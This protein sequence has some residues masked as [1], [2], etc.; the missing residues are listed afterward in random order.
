MSVRDLRAGTLIQGTSDDL[1]RE[2]SGMLAVFHQPHAIDYHMIDSDGTRVD[3]R[4]ESVR[5]LPTPTSGHGLCEACADR[6][7][8]WEREV[9]NAAW[10]VMH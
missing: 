8:P 10:A 5:E 4:T 3:A 7:L 1:A 2:G 9:A 6:L